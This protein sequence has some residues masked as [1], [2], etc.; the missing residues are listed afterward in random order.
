MF[1]LPFNM[2]ACRHKR[3]QS[4]REMLIRSTPA[5]NKDHMSG[6]QPPTVLDSEVSPDLES[7]PVTHGFLSSLFELV[8]T[9]LRSLKRDLS[10]DI[11]DLRQNL[12]SV[13]D[14]V[15]AL[16]DSET[17]QGEEIVMMRQEILCLQEQQE[18][19]RLQAEQLKNT[20]H[21]NNYDCRGPI[22]AEGSDIMEYVQSVFRSILNWGDNTELRLD[23]AYW[24]C[25]PVGP[26]IRLPDVLVYV[27]LF[28]I[29]G[30]ILRAAR[31]KQSISFRARTIDLYQDISPLTLQRQREFKPVMDFLHSK[32]SSH[33]WGHLFWLIFR[34]NGQLHQT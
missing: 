19:L 22:G 12:A 23:R 8:K 28:H 1:H 16:E 6:P 4:V 11:Q 32:E 9:D 13:G 17:A 2:A 26:T 7:A 10:Q 20:S 34:W 5:Q 25:R 3:E 29:K 14:R 24:V 31:A 27:Y 18:G 15:S 21:S 30:D 33:G